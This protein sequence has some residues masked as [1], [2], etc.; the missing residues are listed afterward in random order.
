MLCSSAVAIHKLYLNFSNIKYLKKLNLK[1][2]IAQISDD[3]FI[4]EIME[5]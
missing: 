2:K 3:L 4:G 5:N 1:K